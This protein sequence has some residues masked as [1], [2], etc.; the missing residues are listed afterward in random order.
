MAEPYVPINRHTVSEAILTELE[1]ALDSISGDIA[2]IVSDKNDAFT[3]L[4][5]TRVF[6]KQT[7]LDLM[8]GGR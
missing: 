8:L 7:H 3:A 1:T 2:D 6:E 5:Q 4:V